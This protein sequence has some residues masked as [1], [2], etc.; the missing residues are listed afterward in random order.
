M[1]KQQRVSNDRRKELEQLDPFQENLIKFLDYVKKYKKQLIFMT[2]GFTSVIVIVSIVLFNIKSAENKAL[3][4]LNETL[5]QYN[6]IE[7]PKKAYLEVENNFSKLFED[8][9]NTD[10]G[11]IG[12]IKFAKICYKAS[13]FQKAYELYKEALSVFTDDSTMESLILSSL[14]H[15]CIALDNYKDAELYFT[16]I[17]KKEDAFLMDEALFNL[18][19]IAEQGGRKDQ[20]RK[21]YNTIISEYPDSLYKAIAQNE[22]E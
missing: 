6:K 7:D 15:T 20:S 1:A 19:M 2:C 16:K 10:A 11:R 9:S 13:D 14:G 22:L 18:G 17:V 4:L 21:F 12:K 3:L 5:T 8:Y